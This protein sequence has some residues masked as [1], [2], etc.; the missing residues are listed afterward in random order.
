MSKLAALAAKRRQKENEIHIA[1]ST[2]MGISAQDSASNLS[3]LRIRTKDAYELNKEPAL[4]LRRS[5]ESN[6]RLDQPEV[7]LPTDNTSLSQRKDVEDKRAEDASQPD[8]VQPEE[9]TVELRAEPSLFAQTLVD[10][11]NYASII[12]AEQ[13]SSLPKPVLSSFD[14]SKPSPDDIVLKAQSFKG[15]Q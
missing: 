2:N 12:S 10:P 14:F 6:A 11:C 5:L 13:S 7:S 8:N 15:P 9:R 1:S 3:K 4:K